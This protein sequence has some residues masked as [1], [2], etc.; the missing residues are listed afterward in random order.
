MGP[1]VALAHDYLTQRGGAERVALTM[2]QAFPSAPLYTTLYHPDGT[3]PEF[4]EVDVRPSRLDRVGPLRRNHRL[5]LPLLRGAVESQPVDADVLLAS[6][7]GWA[8][9]YRGA[10][11]T[12]VYCYAPARWLYQ[13]D[14]YLSGA[15]GRT[16]K[17]LW[18]TGLAGSALD[19]LGPGLRRSDA[20]AAARADVYLAVSTVARR[21]VQ[22]VYGIEAEVVPPPPAMD[23]DGPAAAVPGLA[24]GYL[25]CVARLLP[26]KNVDVVVAAAR[27]LRLPLVVVGVG[28]DRERLER[29]AGNGV[30]FVGKVD[31]A[32]LRWLYAHAS[33]LVATSYEDYGLT[34]LEA[35]AFGVPAVTLGTGGYLDTVVDGVTGL[36]V[37][38]PEA[39]PVAEGIEAALARSWDQEA[40][41]VHVKGFSRDA[42]VARLQ[43]VV[44]QEVA[45]AGVSGTHR[46]IEGR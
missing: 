2:A 39:A 25:L 41:G 11:R 1:T 15:S 31:D 19:L 13:R 38:S 42:F 33:L 18:R 36:Y 44:A 26:Y 32:Q 5:A 20:D 45:V 12:V 43:A 6:S 9:R 7:S 23:P 10:R 4:A 28:P 16:W 24:P 21:A 27:R 34:P 30:R 17:D 37:E 3:F 46:E 35:A 40:I 8:H 14:R 22:E 29:L